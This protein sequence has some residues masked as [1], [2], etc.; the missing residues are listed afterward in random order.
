MVILAEDETKSGCGH[1]CRTP[2]CTRTRSGP[3]NGSASCGRDTSG[4]RHSNRHRF[5]YRRRRGKPRCPRCRH[6]GDGKKFCVSQR[7]ASIS[8]TEKDQSILSEDGMDAHAGTSCTH[9]GPAKTYAELSTHSSWALPGD[10]GNVAKE[11][12]Q[13]NSRCNIIRTPGCGSTTDRRDHFCGQSGGSDVVLKAA[14]SVSPSDKTPLIHVSGKSEEVLG[15]FRLAA[16]HAA[17]NLFRHLT[18]C[19]GGIYACRERVGGAQLDDSCEEGLQSV[20][21]SR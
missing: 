4:S 13:S 1:S 21:Q 14:S 6:R 17:R 8:A 15:R 2:R 7:C 5:R 19:C 11:L 16:S 9:S 20:H 3:I 18:L 10:C 12:V